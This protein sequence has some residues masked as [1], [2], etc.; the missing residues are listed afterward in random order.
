MA[1]KPKNSAKK[2]AKPGPKAEVLKL[3]GDWRENIRKSFRA[4]KPAT[5]WPKA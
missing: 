1:A 4:K 5:G 2:K 3:E